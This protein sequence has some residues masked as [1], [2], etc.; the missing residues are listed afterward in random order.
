LTSSGNQS[1]AGTAAQ[2]TGI[3]FKTLTLPSPLQR[4]GEGQ[5]S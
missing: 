1:M 5:M 4:K 2:P 3:G